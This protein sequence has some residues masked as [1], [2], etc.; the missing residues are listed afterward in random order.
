MNDVLRIRGGQPLS[1]AV[2]LSGGKNAA[3][4]LLIAAASAQGPVRLDR[5]PGRLADV[6]RAIAVLTDMGCHF[7]PG[8]GDSLT[9][10]GSSLN[11]L[12]AH[13][14]AGRIRS[15]LL[16][17]A[18]GLGR[19][20]AI[21]LPFPG[22]CAIG[23]R[24]FDVHLA[25]LAALGA[26]IEV[27]PDVIRAHCSRLVGAPITFPVPSTTATQSVVLAAVFARGQ[28]V[29]RNAN[30][31]PENEALF[32]LINR[33][34][35][36][37]TWEP[38]L[39]VVDGTGGLGPGEMAIPS[40]GAEAISWLIAGAMTGGRVAVGPVDSASIRLELAALQRAGLWL[41][42]INDQATLSVSAFDPRAFSLVTSSPPG[43]GSDLQPLFGA[44]ATAAPG[45][46]Q[47]T[48]MRFTERFR[49]LDQLALF[50]AQARSS[51]NTALIQGGRA[52]RGSR[53]VATDLRGGMACVLCALTAEG[54]SEISALVQIDRGYACIED[55]I[56]G[57]GGIAERVPHVVG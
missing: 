2:A 12:R 43:V 1:G 29:L 30:T 17:L 45:T 24:P 34:G 39:V 51:G 26:N 38:R 22:G 13:E 47:I 9:V 16:L 20:G 46:S 52:L 40:S 32:R 4:P 10:N 15:S 33:L 36:R 53:V 7:A 6:K 18:V 49:Y 48:D 37:V 11:A 44:L 28:T 8:P 27:G 56:T 31:R 35:G 3:L 25:G 23:R 21:E 54:L 5:V 57:L 19:L 14:D 50:G 55:T 41:D 42:P